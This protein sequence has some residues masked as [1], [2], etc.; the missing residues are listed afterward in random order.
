M[1]HCASYL[2]FPMFLEQIPA[3]ILACT[4]HRCFIRLLEDR[5]STL[6]FVSSIRIAKGA[7][8]WRNAACSVMNHSSGLPEFVTSCPAER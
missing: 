1:G 6:S 7:A 4:L 8:L 2:P 3:G 5:I